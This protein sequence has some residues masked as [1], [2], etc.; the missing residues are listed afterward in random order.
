MIFLRKIIEE[1]EANKRGIWIPS[2][3]THNYLLEVVSP[4]TRKAVDD[5]LKEAHILYGSIIAIDLERDQYYGHSF[6]T[7]E[8]AWEQAKWHDWPFSNDSMTNWVK[9]KWG[10]TPEQGETILPLK[11]YVY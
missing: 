5:Y 11:V 9:S 10:W 7:V 2:P 3:R 1:E 8:E 6:V 4:K